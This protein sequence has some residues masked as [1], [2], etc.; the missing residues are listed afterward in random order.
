MDRLISLAA[1]AV[2]SS[3]VFA[4]CTTGSGNARLENLADIPP[5]TVDGR[6]PQV[7]PGVL[8]VQEG[9]SPSAVRYIFHTHGMGKTDAKSVLIE[10]VTAALREAGYT[11][12]TIPVEPTWD[13]APTARVH[14]FEGEALSCEGGAAKQPPCRYDHFGQYRVDRFLHADGV[15]RV[16]VYSYLWHDD[17]WRLQRPFL[18]HDLAGLQTGFAGWTA[19]SLTRELKTSIVNEGLSDVAAYLGP[20]GGAL[21]EGMSSAVCI[22][23]REAAGRPVTTSEHNSTIS[24][25]PSDCLDDRGA[26]ALLERDAR[27]SFISHS[28]GSRMLFYVLSAPSSKSPQQEALLAP[29]APRREAQAPGT[30]TKALVATR[31]ATDTFF[32]A[33]NQLSL[34]GIAEV[35]GAQA[36]SPGVTGTAPAAARE[37]PVP[38]CPKSLPG[39][40]T[41]DCRA[42]K[43]S[44]T[45]KAQKS[46]M[47]MSAQ[48][49]I[50]DIRQLKVIGFFD[51]GDILGYSLMGG[52]TGQGPS[53]ISFISV[54]H[55][56]TPQILRL[57][58]NPLVAHDNELAL[59]TLARPGVGHPR[60][61]HAPP[62]PRDRPT[63][64]FMSPNAMAMIFCGARSDPQ[65]RLTPNACPSRR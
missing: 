57:G 65:G 52:R 60:A 12:E 41:A 4:G 14:D 7:F 64:V 21:K 35:K 40:L 33:A 30:P 56:N 46:G 49:A 48:N 62:Y 22:M 37:A 10:P 31:K 27:I 26:Q 3:L 23:L 34:L 19:G 24:L 54:L 59:Q 11:R 63:E 6:N 39:F 51:P 55:R 9:A 25:S 20:A 16:V 17:L 32:M 38:G 29:G 28:L 15:S 13:D 36:T 61:H 1:V 50:D 47:S 45:R 18:A 2:L 42:P 43:D 58:S 8:T 5:T 44:E 53:D